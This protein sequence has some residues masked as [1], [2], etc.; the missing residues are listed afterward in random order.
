MGG[1]VRVRGEEE[2]RRREGSVYSPWQ[3]DADD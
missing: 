2:G 3:G 1:E